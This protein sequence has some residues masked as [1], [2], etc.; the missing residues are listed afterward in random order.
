MK[1]HNAVAYIMKELQAQKLYKRT[2]LQK[3]AYFSFPDAWRQR[4]F[5]PTRYGPFSEAVQRFAQYLGQHKPLI[6]AWSQNVDTAFK[7]VVDN[8]INWIRSQKISQEKII[9]LSKVAYLAR[10]GQEGKDIYKVATVLGWCDVLKE[11]KCKQE[12]KIGGMSNE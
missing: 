3:V 11:S 2:Y 1:I 8:V 4:L 7:K 9:F 10:K 5:K 12:P 6:D